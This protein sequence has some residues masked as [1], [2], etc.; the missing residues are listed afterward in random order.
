MAGITAAQAEEQ[1]TT[2]MGVLTAIG[3]KKSITIDGTTY[4]NHDLEQVRGMVDYWDRKAKELA[5]SSPT[6]GRVFRVVNIS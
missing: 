2:W 4:T 3:A 1:L 6:G 5:S